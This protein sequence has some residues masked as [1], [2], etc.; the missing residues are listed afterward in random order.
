M[1][2]RQKRTWWM[3]GNEP[4]THSVSEHEKREQKLGHEKPLM[5]H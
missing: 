1:V 4:V 3:Q 2:K 5:S